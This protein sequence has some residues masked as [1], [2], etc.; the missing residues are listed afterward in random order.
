MPAIRFTKCHG[1]TNDFVLIDAIDEGAAGL[2]DLPALAARLCDRRRGIGADGVLLLLPDET[3]KGDA[4]L[5]I[6]NADGSEAEMCGNGVRCIARHFFEAR[7]RS[8]ALLHAARGVVGAVSEVRDGRFVGAKVDMGPARTRAHRVPVRTERARIVNEPIV[9]EVA[10][11]WGLP[12]GVLTCISMGNPH[13]VI[14]VGDVGAIDVERIGARVERDAMFPERANVQFVEVRGR[15]R[16]VVRTWERG[17]GPTPA[18]GTGACAAL[19]AGV[20]CGVLD[21]E[22]V[23]ELPGGELRVKWDRHLFM[24]GPAELVY[25]GTFEA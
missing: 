25:R 11:R 8:N 6:F 9:G 13:A 18:C 20:L 7:G 22:A 19:A 21:R 15:G 12:G 17:A 1:L 14:V 2:A 4:R 24:T 3:G 16:A 5:R 23:I 10:A